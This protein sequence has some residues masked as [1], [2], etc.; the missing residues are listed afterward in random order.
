MGYECLLC[1]SALCECARES[2]GV[3]SVCLYECACVAIRGTRVCGYTRACMRG[4]KHKRAAVCCSALQC[5][6]VRRSDSRAQ[7]SKCKQANA[8]KQMLLPSH[9][10]SMCVC[11]CV[12]ARVC[13]RVCVCACLCACAWR[14]LCDTRLFCDEHGAV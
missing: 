12:Y 7:A 14:Y 11:A 4:R 10:S 9:P 5:V 3:S 2:V 8:S 6:V 13:M 1:V